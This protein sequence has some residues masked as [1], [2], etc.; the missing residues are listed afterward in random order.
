VSVEPGTRSCKLRF[1]TL[2]ASL[3]VTLLLVASACVS[4]TS[5]QAQ[6]IRFSIFPHEKVTFGDLDSARQVVLLRLRSCKRTTLVA[7][8]NSTQLDQVSITVRI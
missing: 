6:P 7:Q 5:R 4:Q 1:T 2:L 8:P 3:S